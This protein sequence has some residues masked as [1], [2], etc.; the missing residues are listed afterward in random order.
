MSFIFDRENN[1]EAFK[2]LLRKNNKLYIE[3]SEVL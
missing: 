1:L 3:F 2:K